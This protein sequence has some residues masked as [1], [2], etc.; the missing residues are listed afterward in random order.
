V[1][2]SE[3]DATLDGTL[4]MTT[5]HAKTT[6]DNGHSMALALL[7][8]ADECDAEAKALG[9]PAGSTAHMCANVWRAAASIASARTVAMRAMARASIDANF[10]QQRRDAKSHG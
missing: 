4:K 3:Y 5:N 2:P 8:K 10:A 6:R 1:V 7:S 9:M